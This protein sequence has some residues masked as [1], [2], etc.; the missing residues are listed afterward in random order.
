MTEAVSIS[1]DENLLDSNFLCY[2]RIIDPLKYAMDNKDTHE[3]LRSLF[4]STINTVISRYPIDFLITEGRQREIIEESIS[5]KQLFIIP[6][7]AKRRYYL[8]P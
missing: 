5:G 2:Y 8:K 1:G 4:T 3:I 7:E 6:G